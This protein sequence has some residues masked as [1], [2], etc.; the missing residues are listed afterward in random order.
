LAQRSLDTRAA[1]SALAHAQRA[2]ER[3][4]VPA[5]LTEVAEARAVLERPAARRLGAGTAQPL[6]LAEVEA[7]LGSGALVLD[8]CRRGLRAGASAWPL[9]RR[10]VLFALAQALAKAWPADADRE[11]L[12]ERVFRTRHPDETH[13]VRLRVEM[14]RLT[15]WAAPA[16]SAGWRPRW[17]DSRRSCYSPPRCRLGRV[18][19]PRRSQVH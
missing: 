8:A 11:A 1:L 4:G 2:A 7:V 9:A 17:P 13:R 18:P 15:P 5:L 10:P 3:A 19:S 16:R 12:I 14:G 6:R